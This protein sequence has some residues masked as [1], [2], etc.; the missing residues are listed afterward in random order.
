MRHWTGNKKPTILVL[1]RTTDRQSQVTTAMGIGANSDT[2]VGAV[3][4]T[5]TTT[6]ETHAND[7]NQDIPNTQTP[8][9][10]T[11]KAE[12]ATG[13]TC[14]A[15]G[16]GLITVSIATRETQYHG[17]ATNDKWGEDSRII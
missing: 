3:E 15:N 10:M 5:Y 16:V 2:G 4:S 14:T 7:Q 11:L 1:D 8:V 17:T 13:T 9:S 6:Q 12:T